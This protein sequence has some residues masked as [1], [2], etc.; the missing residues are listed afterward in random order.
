M[1]KQN[2]LIAPIEY[3]NVTAL[4]KPSFINGC[5]S[6]ITERIVPDSLFGL[7]ISEACSIHDYMY[8]LGKDRTKAN[9]VFLDNMI[10]IIERRTNS[11]ILK[12][13]RK[14]KAYIYYYA[15]K[16]FGGFYFKASTT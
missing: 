10:S 12:G 3:W 9:D 7:D 4:I 14:M 15:V 16:L 1:K 13:L 8:E 2:Y 5:G 6:G 11:M